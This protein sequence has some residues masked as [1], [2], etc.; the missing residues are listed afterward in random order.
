MKLKSILGLALFSLVLSNN[1][2][3]GDPPG[4]GRAPSPVLQLKF[5]ML[6]KKLENDALELGR[7]S[8]A[9]MN[10]PGKDF[11]VNIVGGCVI[12]KATITRYTEQVN[13]SDLDETSKAKLIRATS[14]VW[15]RVQATEDAAQGHLNDLRNPFRVLLDLNSGD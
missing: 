7:R 10:G 11:Y 8:P 2:L 9:T 15:D 12:M 13:A 6:L 3:A 1:V 4:L 14:P 5:G